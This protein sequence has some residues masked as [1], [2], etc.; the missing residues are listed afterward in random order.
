MLVDIKPT[1]GRIVLYK[2]SAQDAEATNKR[3]KDFADNNMEGCPAG[4]QSHVGNLVGEGEILPMIIVSVLP[5]SEEQI[6]NGKVFLD[7]NDTLWVTSVAKGEDYG[8]WDWMPFQKDQQAR[9][10][11]EEE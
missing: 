5:G 11:K 6:I 2:L 8:N 4:A 9:L 10:A 3:R 1:I 7:S